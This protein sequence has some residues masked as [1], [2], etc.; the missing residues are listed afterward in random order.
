MNIMNHNSL[1]GFM[2][3]LVI[4]V[5]QMPTRM[6]SFY[7]CIKSILPRASTHIFSRSFRGFK[8]KW[9]YVDEVVQDEKLQDASGYVTTFRGDSGSPFWKTFSNRA[10]VVSIVSSK[11]GPKSAPRTVFS[12]NP[13]LQCNNKA[14]KVTADMVLWIKHH[15]GIPVKGTKRPLEAEASGST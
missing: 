12:E 14:T 9:E 8:E 15:A 1:L 2:T 5:E 13:E 3:Y 7:K 11:V 10:I 6:Q 4:F